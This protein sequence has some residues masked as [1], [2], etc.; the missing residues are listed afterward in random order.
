MIKTF[1]RK[2]VS[3]VINLAM[4]DLELCEID[5]KYKIDMTVWHIPNSHCT[6][7]LAGSL[8]AKSLNIDKELNR[9]PDNIDLSFEDRE[10]LKSLDYFRRGQ[11]IRGFYQFYNLGS[12]FDSNYSTDMNKLPK[13]IIELHRETFITSYE[14]S[15]ATF[16]RDM[17]VLAD[18]FYGLGY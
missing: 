3:T 8:M 14:N 11:V 2:R 7:C 16:K 13:M 10:K 4:N 15:P 9:D 12:D 1:N 6:V 5:P 18:N 17:R